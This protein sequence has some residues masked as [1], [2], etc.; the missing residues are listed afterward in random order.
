VRAFTYEMVHMHKANNST[1][2]SRPEEKKRE[3]GAVGG[4]K[5]PTRLLQSV[6][7]GEGL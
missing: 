2:V 7:E 5:G 4:K 1:L 3:A 6:M